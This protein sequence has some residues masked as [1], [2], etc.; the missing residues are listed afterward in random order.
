MGKKNLKHSESRAKE[1]NNELEKNFNKLWDELKGKMEIENMGNSNEIVFHN[2]EQKLEDMFNKLSV[3]KD[4]EQA[5]EFEMKL[6]KT[7]E[8]CKKDIDTFKLRFLKEK[9]PTIKTQPEDKST[10]TLLPDLLTNTLEKRLAELDNKQK[11]T[12]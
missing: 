4:K 10:S 7:T 6:K 8:E 2:Y 12:Y 9:E 11:E 5:R 3:E 1:K